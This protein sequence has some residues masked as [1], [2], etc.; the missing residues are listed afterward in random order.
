MVWN[1]AWYGP[2]VELFA[3]GNMDEED[4]R[5]EKATLDL[6]DVQL[7]EERKSREEGST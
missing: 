2:G 7:K 5:R 4:R 6:K 3:T 1:F